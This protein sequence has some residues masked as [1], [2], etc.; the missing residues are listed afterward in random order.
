MSTNSNNPPTP[1]DSAC[2]SSISHATHVKNSDCI[3]HDEQISWG[4]CRLCS[5]PFST[6][7]DRR[8]ERVWRNPFHERVVFC[9]CIRFNWWC[10]KLFLIIFARKIR[11]LFRIRDRHGVCLFQNPTCTHQRTAST[12][13]ASDKISEFCTTFWMP[14]SSKA[15]HSSVQTRLAEPIRCLLSKS[16]VFHHSTCW[17]Q[18]RRKGQLCETNLLVLFHT[19]IKY[20]LV[21]F[22]W[23]KTCCFVCNWCQ[24]ITFHW[25]LITSRICW[26]TSVEEVI[27]AQHCTAIIGQVQCLMSPEF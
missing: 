12:E 2:P 17:A 9:A 22:L 19:V 16:L 23:P 13:L 21:R 18:F 5:L 15:T 1:H 25:Y 11:Q 24:R 27:V 20:C 26:S 3:S 10:R 14:T 7:C 6:L 8:E 4:V